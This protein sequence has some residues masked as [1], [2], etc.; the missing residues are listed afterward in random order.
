MSA[1][2]SSPARRR[3]FSN[4]IIEEERTGKVDVSAAVRLRKETKARKRAS[5]LVARPRRTRSAMPLGVG[6]GLMEQDD[7]DEADVE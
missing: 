4:E 1:I 6:W 5:G 7:G 2:C 3:A